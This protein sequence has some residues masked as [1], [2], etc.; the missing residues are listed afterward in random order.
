MDMNATPQSGQRVPFGTRPGLA[1]VTWFHRKPEHSNQHCLYC[2][3]FV[4]VGSV[5]E[6]DKEH[7]INRRIAAPGLMADP[8]A[9]NFI[10]RACKRCNREK[11][12]I[13][14]HISAVTLLTS[15]GREDPLIDAV[16]CAKAAASF[17]RRRG[18][19]VGQVR[20]EFKVAM[21]PFTFGMIAGAQVEPDA[22]RLLAFR[23]VQGIFSLC[24]SLDPRRSETT[25]LLSGDRFGFFSAYSYRD[26]GNPK[27]LE[28]AR[29]AHGYVRLAEFTTADGFFRAALR[30]GPEGDPW[31]WAL[32]WNQNYRIVGWIGDPFTPP[33]PF[34]DLP[35]L[36]W[37]RISPTDR[38]REEAPLPENAEDLLFDPVAS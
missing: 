32:E 37:H 20:H 31:F 35:P 29:R 2:G 17:D 9:F 1:T 7:L 3:E 10:F 27:L 4:G 5:V 6:S 33:A 12:E 24:T 36:T 38:I 18:Q 26:W 16:A 25:R 8:K 28:I 19:P 23:H 15:P 14:D 34:Q 13:E 21:G 11:A 30:P 22:I